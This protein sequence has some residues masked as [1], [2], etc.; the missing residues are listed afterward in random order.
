MQIRYYEINGCQVQ[1]VNT[2][3]GNVEYVIY[4]PTGLTATMLKKYG[5]NFDENSKC[6]YKYL[7]AKEKAEML[8]NMA[9]DNS[10]SVVGNGKIVSEKDKELANKLCWASVIMLAA[11]ALIYMLS[12]VT[13]S[14][15]NIV[16]VNGTQ[17]VTSQPLADAIVAILSV[18]SQACPV[19]GIVT[20][21]IA[22]FKDPNSVF[23]KTLVIVYAV[24][25]ILSILA[26]IAVAVACGIGMATCLEDLQ[27]CS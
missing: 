24:L 18:I 9:P 16:D 19:A 5:F 2:D 27:N 21:I 10:W 3:N 20:A 4:A 11:P 12:L 17:P 8:A 7:N 15:L 6:M 26:I 25:A 23:A 22:K 1:Q 13:L 14:S